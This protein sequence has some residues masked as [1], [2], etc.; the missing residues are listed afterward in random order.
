MRFGKSLG[1]CLFPADIERS[2]RFPHRLISNNFLKSLASRSAWV[3]AVVA[4]AVKI[5]SRVLAKPK[6]DVQFGD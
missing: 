6:K 4:L 5:H 2:A 1:T 3:D